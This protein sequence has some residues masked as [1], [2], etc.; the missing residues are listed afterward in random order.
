MRSSML[1]RYEGRYAMRV[2]VHVKART[3]M[4]TLLVGYMGFGGQRC[5]GVSRELS[6]NYPFSDN[7]S[8][9]PMAGYRR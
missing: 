3:F 2:P 7:S 6:Q 9:I 1:P 4:V 8:V 5:A